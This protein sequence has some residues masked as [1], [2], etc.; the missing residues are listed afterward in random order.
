[1]IGLAEGCNGGSA[2]RYGTVTV[3]PVDEGAT[4][5][6]GVPVELDNGVGGQFYDATCGA[7]CSDG[8]FLWQDDDWEYTIGIKAGLIDALT[9][10]ATT[11][12]V[13]E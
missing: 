7:N 3:I 2:C 1:V 11:V 4:D 6:F 12:I 9:E 10:S 5:L 8:M 13:I